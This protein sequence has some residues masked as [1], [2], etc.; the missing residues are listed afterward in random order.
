MIKRN[1]EWE[2]KNLYR[3]GFELRLQ[4]ILEYMD[5]KEGGIGDCYSI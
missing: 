3:K 1:M 4:G 2:E 5:G